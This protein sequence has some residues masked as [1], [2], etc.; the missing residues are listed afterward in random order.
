MKKLFIL[1]IP[2]ILWGCFLDREVV[3]EYDYSYKGKFK[4]YK[5]YDIAKLDKNTHPN[6]SEYEGQLQEAIQKR[7]SFQRYKYNEKKPDLLVFYKVFP[8][9]FGFQGF[10]QPDI[11]HWMKRENEDEE[12]EP[13]DLSLKRGTLFISLYDVKN[14]NSIWQ[15]YTS[16]VFGSPN[17]N[18][19][20]SLARAVRIVFDQYRI[21]AENELDKI[22]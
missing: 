21:F 2:F 10:D 4:R 16:G 7:M 22:N 3:R 14:D 1:I 5:T 20:K 11:E 12:Y 13:V 15:G 17:I 19:E 6:F 18:T 9:N 8:E